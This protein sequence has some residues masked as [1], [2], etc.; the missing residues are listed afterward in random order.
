MHQKNIE[1]IVLDVEASPCQPKTIAQA[2]VV[3]KVVQKQC[4][5]EVQS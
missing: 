2:T 3:G 5:C 1:N 4:N